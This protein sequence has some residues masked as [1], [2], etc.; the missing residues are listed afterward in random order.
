MQR[1]V[2]I[3]AYFFICA[4]C[5]AQQYPFVHYTPKDGLPS[6]RVRNICQDSRGRIFFS[7][8]NGLSMYDGARFTNYTTEDGLSS[9]IINCVMEMGNDSI[10]IATNTNRLNCLVRSKIKTVALKDSITPVINFLCRNDAGDLYAAADDGLFLFYQ[11]SFVKLPLQNLQGQDVNSYISQLISYGNYLIIMRDYSL[12]STAPKL[13]YLFDCSQKKIVSQTSG[14][15][16]F[17]VAASKEG[18]VWLSTSKN[19][20]QLDTNALKRGLIVQKELPNIFRDFSTNAGFIFFDNSNNCWISDGVHSLKKCDHQGNIT[21]YT[22]SSGLG[23]SSIEY[24][25]Q[26]KESI[27][28]LASKGAGVEK[29]MHSNL[30]LIE[31]P[32]GFINT[33]MIC[34]NNNGELI[35]YSHNDKKM[36]LLTKNDVEINEIKSTDQF[37]V[38]TATPDG[39]FGISDKK[40]FRLLK[41]GSSIYTETIFN[42]SSQ[43]TFGNTVAD[44]NGN[45]IIIGSQ[46]L[47]ALCNNTVS[48]VP[49]NDI[50]DQVAVDKENNVWIATR[51][52]QLI[53]F[54]THPENVT[55]YLKKELVFEKELKALQPRSI[56]I[57]HKDNIWIGTRYKGL[58]VFRL[59]K[60]KLIPVFRLT[61]KSGLTDNFISWLSCDDE[62]NI[63]AASPSGLDKIHIEN[64]TPIIENLTRQNNMYQ[65]MY[66]VVTDK[67][68]ITWA[69]SSEGLIRISPV[70]NSN[71]GYLPRLMITQIRAGANELDQNMTTLSYK[72]NNLSFYFTAPSFLGEK[73]ILYS[74]MLQGSS[75]AEWSEP[76]NNSF[77]SFIDLRPGSYTLHI[78]AKFPAGRYP[79]QSL[80]YHFLITPPWW[81]TWW[82]RI[83]AGILIT[84]LLISGVR[85]YYNRKLEKQKTILEKQ[86][87]IEH[88][89]SRI[90]A[91]MHD[92][93]GAGL[94]NIK[95]ITE[96]ILEKTESGETI[97][98]ELEKLKNFSSE[99][100]ESMGEIIWAVSEKNN[101]LTNTLYYLRSYAINYCEENDLE[102]Y[103]EIPESFRDR[104]VSGNVRRNIF[105][106]L[107]ESLHNIVK[108]AGAKNIT[109]RAAI[110]EELKLVIKDDGKGFSK[111]GGTKGN[112]LINM[113]KRVQ[114]LNGSISFENDHGAAVIIHL[115]FD[116]NQRT[117]G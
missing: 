109:I 71:T 98:P 111:N 34:R 26:D 86:Q 6:N 12:V 58:Y 63:W 108:H 73:Q 94:T 60:E 62:S 90:A 103:F 68:N 30:S 115:P 80:Q 54:S 72:Q 57:D 16:V 104:I 10:W 65:F 50:S 52:N 96:H 49:V 28:W 17:T 9:D 100:V 75:H 84:G 23:N 66:S 79:E 24:V 7:T 37:F 29:L 101:L 46:Y 48:Q 76:S 22:K 59:E 15:P 51:A 41:K 8:L 1:T 27:I 25:F 114:E 99:L 13:L 116:T 18:N 47:T 91:D 44:K 19:I 33:G 88:E 105:L 93:L 56:A 112:G 53:R 81:Q 64:D 61:S 106:L 39:L 107:K 40:I 102:C 87:A 85:F 43:N 92:D 97:K 77:A 21:V 2:I 83:T 55:N 36:A 95:Y 3:L 31:R 14:A 67:N 89:R 11:N 117:I 35:L 20:Q 82:L 70:S 74:Y 78:K 45:L 110:T 4:T 69:M 38:V 32:F 5:F 42:D 113:K